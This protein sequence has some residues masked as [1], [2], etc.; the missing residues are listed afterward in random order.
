MSKVVLI[1]GGTSGLGEA[2]AFAFSKQKYLVYAAG[3]NIENKKESPNLKYIYLDVTNDEIINKAINKIVS[4]HNKI[5]I[6]INNA[7]IGVAAALEEISINEVKHA[8][9]INLFGTLRLIKSVVPHMRNQGSGLI[10]N[11]SS[12]AGQVGLPFQGIY[13]STKFA[14]EGMTEALQTEL[15]PF[16]IK[17]CLVEP[18]DYKTKVNINRKLVVPSSESPYA[19][20]LE[21]FFSIIDKNIE[22][23][24]NPEKL[25]KLIVRISKMKNPRLRYRSGRVFER[26]TP[27]LHWI[28]PPKI[29]AKVLEIFYKL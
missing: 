16:E 4:E 20:R 3:R 10:I 17:V 18:G 28:I 9:D 12:I 7:G 21:S 27:F 6:L 5:D 19:N 25:A 26:I 14:L 1:T 11:I 8:F 24:R 13:S 23:G 22:K 29:F 15:K 2:M